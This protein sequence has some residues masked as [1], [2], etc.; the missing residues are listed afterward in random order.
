MGYSIWKW[1]LL[2]LLGGAAAAALALLLI[3]QNDGI[4]VEK[5]VSV[6]PTYMY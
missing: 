2:T 5:V 6:S 4:G 3:T 1:A